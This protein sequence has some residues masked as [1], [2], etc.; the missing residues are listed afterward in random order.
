MVRRGIMSIIGGTDLA[1]KYAKIAKKTVRE[2][3]KPRTLSGELAVNF[4]L[5]QRTQRTQWKSIFSKTIIHTDRMNRM[6]R[7]L[8][9]KYT[10]YANPESFRGNRNSKTSQGRALLLASECR[11]CCHCYHRR[12]N[13]RQ[14]IRPQI[15]EKPLWSWRT[16]REEVFRF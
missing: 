10:N 3:R 15:F 1:T 13:Q 9:A 6:G 14:I 8:T 2:L 5:T 12:P 16:W 11:W 7:I 4:F